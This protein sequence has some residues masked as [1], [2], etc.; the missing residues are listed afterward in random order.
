VHEFDKPLIG[1]EVGFGSQQ[2]ADYKDKWSVSPSSLHSFNTVPSHA[3]VTAAGCLPYQPP[4]NVWTAGFES[5]WKNDV[6]SVVL[7]WWNGNNNEWSAT[8]TKL[9]CQP[10]SSVDRRLTK[11]VKVSAP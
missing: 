5:T 10:V 1:P 7:P 2:F 3:D 4:C 11:H 8:S 9:Q 6:P